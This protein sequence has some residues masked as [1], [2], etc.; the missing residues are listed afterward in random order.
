MAVINYYYG[1]LLLFFICTF[2]TPCLREGLIV[3]PHSW[4]VQI[5]LPGYSSSNCCPTEH[6]LISL[7]RAESPQQNGKT[8]FLQ[9]FGNFGTAP[10]RYGTFTIGNPHAWNFQ[11]L[12]SI[13]SF[14]QNLV[15]ILHPIHLLI[16]RWSGVVS[17][18]EQ[19]HSYRS[20][21]RSRRANR[22]FCG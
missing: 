4:N 20:G 5:I 3:Q 21:T 22:I 16:H 12:L 11:I 1:F 14:P 18:M 6:H 8:Q 2:L 15:T 7:L 17:K 19:E 10:W 9:H 13:C